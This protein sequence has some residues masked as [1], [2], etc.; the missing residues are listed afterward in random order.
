MNPKQIAVSLLAQTKIG[1]KFVSS[2]RYRAILFAGAA[3]ALNLLY[4]LYHCALGILNRSLWF[5]AM[6]AFYGILATMRF[7]AVLCGRNHHKY[8]SDDS[9]DTEQFV[10]KFSG[11]LL[12]ALAAV[13]AAVNYISLSQNI[14]AKYEEIMMITIA[15]YTFGKITMAGVKAVKQRRNPS[16]LLRTIR[17]IGYAE[18][19]ASLLTLQRSMLLS[20]GS[21]DHRQIRFMNAM[22]GAA[23]CLFVLLLGVSMIAKSNRIE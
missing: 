1:E 7:A 21:M 23:V 17:T 14:A 13:L 18:V 2:Q 12:L 22:T 11:I 5:I 9:D 16:P 6:C 8:P 4:A 19:S 3:F 15:A 20:F 10:M